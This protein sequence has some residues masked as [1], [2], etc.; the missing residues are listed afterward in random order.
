LIIVADHIKINNKLKLDT[1]PGH[2]ADGEEKDLIIDLPIKNDPD[3]F[4][5]CPI[6]KNGLYTSEVT[7]H[8]KLFSHGGFN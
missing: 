1:L 7:R 6:C 5:N 8:F 2:G 3:G 4:C